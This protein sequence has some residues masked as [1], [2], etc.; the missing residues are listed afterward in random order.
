MYEMKVNVVYKQTGPDGESWYSQYSLP[1]FYLKSK[2]EHDAVNTAHALVGHMP[3]PA[4]KSELVYS[5]TAVK[6]RLS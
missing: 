3:P 2:T 1:T 5:V 6:V 4:N